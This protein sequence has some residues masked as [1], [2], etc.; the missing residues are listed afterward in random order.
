LRP[1]LRAE[2][3]SWLVDPNIALLFLV[4]GA[5]LIY[6]EFNAPG[7]IVPGSLGTLMVLL[8]IFGLNLLPIRYTAVMLLVAALVL[9]LLEA[10]FGAHGVLAIAGIVCLTFGTLT[11]VAAPVPEMG[12]TP[13]VAFAVSAGFGGITVFLVR[14]AV[15]A[16]RRK[17]LIGAEAMVGC[18][19]IA[20]EPLVPEGH[21]LVEGE[22][23]LAI[24]DEPLPK[25]ASLRVASQEQMLLHVVPDS[26]ARMPESAA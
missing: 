15:R 13:W 5:L 12:V 1:S 7:T 17:A 23:W 20:M 3:L 18:K 14:L 8:A 4:G 24:A 11:L 2:L 25:G 6:L 9:L 19:A 10:K 22:I 21:V 16:R 26:A